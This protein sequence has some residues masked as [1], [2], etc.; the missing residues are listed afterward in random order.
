MI[1]V[2]K[3]DKQIFLNIFLSFFERQAKEKFSNVSC[4]DIFV[5]RWCV[6]RTVKITSVSRK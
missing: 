1:S 5:Y 3:Q 4:G 6:L 2:S